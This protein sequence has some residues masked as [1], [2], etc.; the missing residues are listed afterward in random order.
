MHAVRGYHIHATDGSIGH[1]ENFLIDD[2]TWAVRYLII[3]TRNW[4]P[5]AH[6]LISPYAVQS[7]DWGD[8]QI[9][10]NVTREKV[11]ASPPWN[12]VEVV[13]EMY[14]RRLHGYYG[15]PGYGW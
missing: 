8:Q 7:I 11:K 14:E 6:V 15:W 2:V 12:P 9:H 5:G 13:E 4:W 3:D 1:V 10:L